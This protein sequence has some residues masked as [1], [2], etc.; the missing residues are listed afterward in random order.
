MVKGLY[1]AWTAMINEQHR[2]DVATNNLANANTTAY[3]KEGSS[4]QTFREQLALKIKD[5]SEPGTYP[6]REGYIVP[7]VRIGEEY[8]DW[9][10]G[11]MKNTDNTWDLAISGKGF[12]AIDYTSKTDNV[13]DHIRGQRTTM[14]TRDGN[15]TLTAAGELV[16][17]DG[18]FVLDTEDQHIVVDP[19][20]DAQ[21]NTHGEIIQDGEVVATIGRFDFE[22]YDTLAKYGENLY[23]PTV[24][25]VRTTAPNAVIVQGFL[26]QSNVS[27]VDE[28]VNIINIQRH[29][30]A[31]A[32]LI[33]T[34]DDTLGKA[35]E[36]IG[37]IGG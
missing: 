16:T 24:E 6:R 28:M 14:Y 22:D 17:Q 20:K 9:T 29:Y 30:E 15:L 7:G 10:E 4:Q 34:A 13:A 26:E 11:P 19:T 2:M 1:T 12:F 27:V 5:T 8:T 33:Q 37:R 18:D 21:V 35:V 31:A 36:Q 25:A 32:T 3:K 23:E